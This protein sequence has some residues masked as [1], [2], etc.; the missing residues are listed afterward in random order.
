MA[1]ARYIALMKHLSTDGYDLET[2][3][4]AI[5]ASAPAGDPPVV[6]YTLAGHLLDQTSEDIGIDQGFIFPETS[7]QRVMRN[8]IP[9]QI[10]VTGDVQ[11]PFY[12]T[13]TPTL[14]YYALGA[15][16]T[17]G[18][19]PYVHTIKADEP[20]I[21]QMAVGKDRKEHRFA[22]CVVSS[23]TIDYDPS[24]TVLTTFSIMARK[25]LTG[26]TLEPGT[27]FPDYNILERAIG[28]TEVSTKIGVKVGSATTQASVAAN[29]MESVSIEVDNGFV[30]DNYVLGSRYIPE[31][32]EQNHTLTGSMEIGYD[33]YARYKAVVDE[34]QWKVDLDG[35]TRGS[36][37][38]TR[39]IQVQLPL[40]T[41]N[42]ANLPT[43]GTDRYILSVDF[44]GQ[45]EGASDDL[46]VVKVTNGE[47]N[48]SL[49]K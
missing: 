40:V 8:R 17:T 2:W 16:S 18:S 39:K 22:G 6:T 26:A 28:G 42:T 20:K 34:N 13:G 9:G 38:T 29:Y 47:N 14:I 41:L 32:Y 10:A 12:S 33:D 7:A 48:T 19:G 24:E 35:V 27:P 5:T 43:E 36:A 46:I 31:A 49:V 1:S 11:V 44:T 3:K 30:D 4:D 37:G 21:F 23:M 15:A 25:E 45:R